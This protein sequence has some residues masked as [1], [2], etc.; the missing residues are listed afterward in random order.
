MTKKHN[1][2]I[3]FLRLLLTG[4]W[5]LLLA[6]Q[7]IGQALGAEGFVLDNATGKGL[8]F[9]NI[10]FLHST[11]G[12]TTDSTGRFRIKSF[13]PEDTLIFSQIGYRT[14]KL[15]MKPG[16]IFHV[17]V[18]MKEDNLTLGEV[19]I[20]PGENPAFPIIRQIIRHRKENDPNR[21][22]RFS[23]QTYTKIS[24]RFTNIN[25]SD[26]KSNL[27]KQL[28]KY[29]PQQKDNSKMGFIPLFYSEKITKTFI[30]HKKNMS[31][32]KVVA[33]K[34][35]GLGMLKDLQISRYSNSLSTLMNFY[36]NYVDLLGHNF[37]SPIGGL[38]RQFY[39]YY[40]ADSTLQN[41][42][43]IYTIKYV[44][45]NN[46]DLAF[47]GKFIVIKGLWAIQDIEASL[48]R[49]A[50]VNFLNKFNISY[51][52]QMLNDSVSFFKSNQIT[53][54]FNYNKLPNNHRSMLEI[55]KYTAYKDVKT[56]IAAKPLITVTN[57]QIAS[58]KKAVYAS[59]SLFSHFTNSPQNISGNQ[60]SR[61]IDSINHIGW[62]KFFNKTTDMFVTEYY[63]VGK[64]EIGPFL[65]L[66]QFNRVEGLRLSF[67]GRTGALFNPNY[68]IGAMAGYGF[69]DKQWKYNTFFTWKFKT[70]NRTI[71]RLHASKDLQLFGV[72]GHIHLIKENTGTG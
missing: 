38:G 67:G 20:K 51:R 71:L 46:K 53:A 43:M 31:Q 16:T 48:P 17:V 62:V 33:F 60:I 69:K 42:R 32:T 14:V 23:T 18:R 13:N 24:T 9:T 49:I 54:S 10:Y 66:A 36:D 58:V 12:T 28:Q 19:V 27:L 11:I 21:L 5:L 41:G 55:N 47:K 65:N 45:K 64:Y 3:Y 6:Q 52:Y 59:D 56:G 44:P 30:D 63:N 1:Y 50:N 35:N 40:L 72:Y 22:E 70:Q 57:G 26:I 37:V 68:S 2:S 15:G 34:E 39:K 29:L 4:F 25:L 61:S 7:A 8:P